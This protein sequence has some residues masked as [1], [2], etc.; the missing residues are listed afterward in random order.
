[1]G[2]HTRNWE[3]QVTF[4][5][6][7]NTTQYADGDGVA[8][9]ATTPT[10]ATFKINGVA[11]SQG[12]GGH[13]TDLVLHK[14]DQDQTGADFSVYFFNE[15]PAVTGFN[16]NAAIA[17][18]DAEFLTCQNFVALTASADAENV[19]TGDIYGKSNL[20]ISYQCAPDDENTALYVVIVAR[21]TY[22]PASG[23][24]F[25]LTVKGR[26]N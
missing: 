14:S 5:R 3:R 20:D 12:F 8:D 16:D 17:I 19:V 2:A 22:T 9:D 15:A 23:E 21:G 18:T 24:T 11:P 7:A 25:T 1:M 6:P 26:V 13:I 10:A 4:D